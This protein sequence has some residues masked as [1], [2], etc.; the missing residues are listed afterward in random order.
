M[1]QAQL[2]DAIATAQKALEATLGEYQGHTSREADAIIAQLAGS[3][4]I[5]NAI[6]GLDASLCQEGRETRESLAQLRD[7]LHEI[8]FR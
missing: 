2:N 4:I 5:A 8:P 6:A 1:N 7:E 3:I